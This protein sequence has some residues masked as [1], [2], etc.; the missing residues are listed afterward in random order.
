MRPLYRR[1]SSDRIEPRQADHK[2][3]SS[4][5]TR[6]KRSQFATGSNRSC[7]QSRSGTCCSIS[8][9]ACG[10]AASRPRRHR[11]QGR[12]SRPPGTRCRS[13]IGDERFGR[14]ASGLARRA[15]LRRAA[16][17]NDASGS[18]GHRATKRDRSWRRAVIESLDPRAARAR[19]SSG[20]VDVRDRPVSSH[21]TQ[22]RRKPSDES[23]IS[24]CGQRPKGVIGS[25]VASLPDAQMTPRRSS[26]ASTSSASTCGSCRP[27]ASTSSACSGGS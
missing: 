11:Q 15:L 6:Q 27:A 21:Q 10:N 26:I 4:A 7:S 25:N 14:A 1:P 19:A 16:T 23:S 9:T 3:Q 18:R 12:F 17:R 13:A 2:L 22:P 20:S 24:S 8:R 5:A